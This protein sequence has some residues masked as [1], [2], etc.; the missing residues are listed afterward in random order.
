M[1]TVEI[2]TGFTKAELRGFEKWY[3][4][5]I[6][7]DYEVNECDFEELFYVTCYDVT[8]WELQKIQAFEDDVYNRRDN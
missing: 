4:R 1:F 6:G 3:D 8:E 2:D 5:E 7:T